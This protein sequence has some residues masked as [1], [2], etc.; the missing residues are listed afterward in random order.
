MQQHLYFSLINKAFSSH[1]V[2]G[3]Q[4]SANQ[5]SVTLDHLFSFKILV[6][7]DTVED[8]FSCLVGKFWIHKSNLENEIASLALTKDALLQSLVK[9]ST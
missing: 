7:A 8:L 5:A 3:A 6:G 1:V 9:K 4:G 2:S